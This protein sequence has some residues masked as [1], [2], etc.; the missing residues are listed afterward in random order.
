MKHKTN[1]LLKLSLAVALLLAVGPVR[2]QVGTWRY[3]FAATP[4]EQ[5]AIWGPEVYASREADLLCYNTVD[6]TLTTLSKRN[7]LS[8]GDIGAIAYHPAGNC[9]IIGYKDGNIDLYYGDRVFNMSDIKE[10]NIAGGNDKA[11]YRIHTEGAYAYLACGFGVVIVDVLKR[12]F[13]ETY[14]IGP[15]NG[16]LRVNEVNCDDK[17]IWAATERGLR[18]AGKNA[19]NLND[20][21]AWTVD[22]FWGEDRP[23]AQAVKLGGTWWVLEK[24]VDGAADRVY[25]GQLGG[26][27]TLADTTDIKEVSCLRAGA[28]YVARGTYRSSAEQWSVDLLS[29]AGGLLY[30]AAIDRGYEGSIPNDALLDARQNLWTV[31]TW[32][33]IMRFDQADGHMETFY[34]WGPAFNTAMTMTGRADRIYLASG[35]YDASFAPIYREGTVSVFDGREWRFLNSHNIEGYGQFSANVQVL[36]DPS[37]PGHFYWASASDGLLEIRDNKVVNQFTDANSPLQAYGGAVRVYGIALDADG[38]VWMTNP[39]SSTAL[40]EY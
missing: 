38:D 36:E 10:K 39:G 30:R 28:N 5:L 24:G 26:A 33:S 6:R 21:A 8:G 9:L 22:A 20:Y 32:A 4:P 1:I 12:E 23:L 25:R 31:G 17:Y 2:A 35:G 13:R 18:F 37:E 11:V 29:E 40:L 3:H 15:L 34:Y 16:S 14:F 7:G 19:V 27:W